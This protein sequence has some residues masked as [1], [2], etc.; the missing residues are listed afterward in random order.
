MNSLN[1][2]LVGANWAGDDKKEDFFRRGSWEMGYG[3]DE[4]PVFTKRR[5]QIK[6]GD[7][8]ALKSM[9]G[10]GATTITIKAIGVVKD[11]SDKIIYIDWKLA[12]L[13]RTVQSHGA[14][15]TIHGPYPF[16]DN[17]IQEIFCL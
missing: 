12:D 15:G 17:R 8:I 3:D 7:R 14:L 4:K 9:D 16:S 11:I 10:Y 5:N 2:L 6:I 13:N 1:Y